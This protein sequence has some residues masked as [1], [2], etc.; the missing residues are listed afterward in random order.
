MIVN[1]I[2]RCKTDS[3][4][5]FSLKLFTSTFS[6]PNSSIRKKAHGIE[7]VYS[8]LEFDNPERP[9]CRNLLSIYQIITGKTKEVSNFCMLT[10]YIKQALTWRKVLHMDSSMSNIVF[11]IWQ[12][13][14]I[15]LSF[16]GSCE[17]VP[18]YELGNI[19]DYPYRCFDWAFATYSGL[20][21]ARFTV[22]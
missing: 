18:R 7:F 10:S 15:S 9:E 21:I 1:K 17:R 20:R 12:D 16:S 11:F 14:L 5:G 3:F 6:L 4:P 19:Q 2:K 8:S 13:R 22:W